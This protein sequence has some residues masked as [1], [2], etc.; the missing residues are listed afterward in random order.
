MSSRHHRKP[1][2]DAIATIYGWANPKT[3]ELLVSKRGLPN[4][5]EGYIPNRPYKPALEVKRDEVTPTPA[6]PTPPIAENKEE[7]APQDNELPTP[8]TPE[9]L[10]K[11]L[12]ADAEQKGPGRPT[13]VKDSVKRAS[14][15]SKSAND[16]EE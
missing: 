11:L 10:D 13:G 7:E 16:L 12:G 15:K 1:T 4:P 5:V 8:N 3:G 14:R 6:E 9:D 2:P